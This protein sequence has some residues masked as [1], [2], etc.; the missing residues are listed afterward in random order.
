MK[1]ETISKAISEAR[2]VGEAVNRILGED[3]EISSGDAV[4]IDDPTYSLAG[5]R[6]SVKGQSAKGAGFVD[7]TTAS[8]MT[9]PLQASLLLKVA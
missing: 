7:C 2:S 5:Q 4:V 6:V 8:G 3:I 1:P 9:V